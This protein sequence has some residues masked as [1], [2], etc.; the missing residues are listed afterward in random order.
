MAAGED[1]VAVS[2]E[3]IL[4]FLA[5]LDG[6]FIELLVADDFHFQPSYLYHT[7]LSAG[8]DHALPLISLAQ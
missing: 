7:W 3:L 2:R 5:F 4:N 6:I 8:S 1:V